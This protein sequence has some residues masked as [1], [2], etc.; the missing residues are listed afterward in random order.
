MFVALHTEIKYYFFFCLF[1]LEVFVLSKCISTISDL[2]TKSW[3]NLDTTI[4][5]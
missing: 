1:I 2:T 4:E 5:S 3:D